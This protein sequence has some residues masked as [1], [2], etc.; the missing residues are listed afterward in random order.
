MQNGSINGKKEA[1]MA[2]ICIYTY[3]HYTNTGK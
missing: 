2:R 3:N 1:D